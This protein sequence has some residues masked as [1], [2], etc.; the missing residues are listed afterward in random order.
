MSH[1]EGI[2]TGLGVAQS[3]LHLRG[4][5]HLLGVVGRHTKRLTAIHD[6]FT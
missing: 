2:E 5:Q 3:C 6:I 4:L 1:V